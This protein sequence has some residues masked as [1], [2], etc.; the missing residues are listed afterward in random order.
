MSGKREEH[1]ERNLGSTLRGGDDRCAIVDLS[2]PDN[3]RELTY[4]QLDNLADGAAR[5][6]ADRGVGRAQ[7]V[8]IV[9]EN[10]LEFIAA[11]LGIMRVGAVAVPV[12][13][14]FPDETLRF[15]FDDSAITITFADVKNAGRVP[16]PCEVLSL[17]PDAFAQFVDFGDFQPITP[18]VRETGLILYTSGSTGRPKGVLLSHASQWAMVDRMRGNMEGLSGTVAAPLYH[19]NG[20]LMSFNLMHGRGTVV[21]MPRFEAARYLR[22]LDAYRVNVVTGVP[23][24]LSLMARERS[25]IDSLDLSCVTSVAIGSAPLSETVIAETLAMFPGA[26][27]SN[28]YGTTEAGAGMFG[29]H[30][31]GVPTPPLALGYPASHVEIRLVD[32]RSEAKCLE[33]VL[34]VRTPAAMNGYLNNPEK[35]AEKVNADGWI[36]TGDI[37]RV[38]EDGFYYFVGRNDDMFVC[39]GENIFPGEV[40]RILEGDP[41]IVEAC[42]VPVSDA[43]RGQMPVAFVTISCPDGIDEQAVKDVVLANAPPHMHPRHVHFLEE[44]PLAGT[45]KIDRKELEDRANAAARSAG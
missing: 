12:N 30:P 42:V 22:A 11:L 35:T 26:R 32:V 7:T 4:T 39:G 1:E 40:E 8:G 34:E 19:M 18:N 13:F 15:V 14:K 9:A 31:D 38:D 36:D 6:L 23:T 5:A 24:M 3:P 20:M 21:L 25:L 10:S 33:G 29:R 27:L 41:R 16:E 2:D 17:A 37:M 28:G 43:V 44:M 45:N